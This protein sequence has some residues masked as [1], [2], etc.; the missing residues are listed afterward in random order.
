[1]FHF[2]FLNNI[3][4]DYY[5]YVE[6]NVV[7][8]K[9]EKDTRN[10][11]FTITGLFFLSL[12]FVVTS[13]ASEAV[14]PNPT[15]GLQPYSQSTESDMGQTRT[16]KQGDMYHQEYGLQPG[17]GTESGSTGSDMKH[18]DMYRPDYWLEDYSGTR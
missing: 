7:G 9:E 17:W 18:G 1:M 12:L 8:R 11:T 15:Q 13:F 10:V 6:K 14:I 4:H 2:L 3:R 5:F 16:L